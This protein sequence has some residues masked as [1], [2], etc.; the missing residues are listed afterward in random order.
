M[1]AWYDSHFNPFYRWKNWHLEKLNNVSFKSP[2]L[3]LNSGCQV[4]GMTL[5]PGGERS[6]FLT[7]DCPRLC[8]LRYPTPLFHSYRSDS[9]VWVNTTEEVTGS[10]NNKSIRSKQ[11]SHPAWD[12]ASGHGLWHH[13]TISERL[14]PVRRERWPQSWRGLPVTHLGS[15]EG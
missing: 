2:Q 9:L 4:R 5:S 13:W 1:T 14:R 3:G 11:S 12:W 7:S 6:K 8:L 10:E 15:P